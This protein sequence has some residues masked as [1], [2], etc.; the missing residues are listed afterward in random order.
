MLGDT[1]VAINPEDE[2]HSNWQN[3]SVMLPLM[4]REIPIIGDHHADP[5]K[6]SGAVKITPAHDFD[7]FQVGRRHDLPA[8]RVIGEDGAFRAS[9]VELP[10]AELS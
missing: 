6:G 5:E 1:A 8:V 3:S 10:F 4:D 2:R 9:V 7:D